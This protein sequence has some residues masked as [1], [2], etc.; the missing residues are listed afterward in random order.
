[1]Q[2]IL[3]KTKKSGEPFDIA[4]DFNLKLLDHDTSKKGKIFSLRSTSLV[5][6][7]Q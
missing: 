2:T 5:W 4:G 7:Q 1:M 6:Y 3:S